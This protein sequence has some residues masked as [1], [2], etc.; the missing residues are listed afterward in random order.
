MWHTIGPCWLSILIIAVCVR[1][2][3]CPTLCDPMDCSPTV[4][5][6]TALSVGFSRQG[7]WSGLP[8]SSPAVCICTQFYD[9]LGTVLATPYWTPAL[10][11]Y[12]TIHECCCIMVVYYEATGH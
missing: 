2:Q 9:A 5:H 12:K 3:S 1:A 7:C 11:S 8:F 6:E 4:A 10:H